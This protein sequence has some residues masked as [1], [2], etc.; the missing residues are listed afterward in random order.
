MEDVNG[1]KRWMGSNSS[2]AVQTIIRVFSTILLNR[3]QSI[4][5]G[6]A[7]RKILSDLITSGF[8]PVYPVLQD[9]KSSSLSEADCQKLAAIDSLLGLGLKQVQI[10]DY[11]EKIMCAISEK[12]KARAVIGFRS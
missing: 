5:R 10:S 3:I 11:L 9:K 12:L 8:Q 2:T 4:V 1:V 7:P 6:K